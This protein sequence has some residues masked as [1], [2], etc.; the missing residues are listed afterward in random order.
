MSCPTVADDLFLAASDTE[1]QL[2]FNLAYISQ[3]KRYTI[4]PQNT[5]TQ[6]RSVKMQSVRM[7]F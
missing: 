6:F 7:N 4:H 3:E 1:L 5:I 2:M